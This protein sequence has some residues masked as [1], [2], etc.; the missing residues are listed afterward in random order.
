MEF[1]F[2][3][4]LGQT[5]DSG[6]NNGPM[7]QELQDMF[8]AADNS[9]LWHSS[10]NHVRCYAHKLNLTVGHGL[11][12]LGQTVK[13]LK[14]TIPRGIP[15]PVPLLEVND[16]DD[17]IEMDESESDED[18][19]DGLPDQPDGIDDEDF[20]MDDISEDAV[21]NKDDI[22][23]LALVKVSEAL[24]PLIFFLLSYTFICSRTLTVLLINFS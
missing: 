5:T 17:T 24:F 21:I 8:A 7:A 18:D 20:I 4:L 15:L 14:P 1:Y 16:G 19:G 22:V 9:V 23:A 10:A 13:T 11:R 3:Y 6:G 2:A 12:V